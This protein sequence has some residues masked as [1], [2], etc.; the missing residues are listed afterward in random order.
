MTTVSN[1]ANNNDLLQRAN[2][3]PNIISYST[4][5]NQF[6]PSILGNNQNSSLQFLLT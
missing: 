1:Q 3:E 5:L 6:S 4:S 2:S